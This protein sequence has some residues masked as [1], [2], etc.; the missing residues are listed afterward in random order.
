MLDHC[1]VQL[2][3]GLKK[4]KKNNQS[5]NM[6]KLSDGTYT[7]DHTDPFLSDA[8]VATSNNLASATQPEKER[9]RN[10]NTPKV[11]FPKDELQK[12]EEKTSKSKQ[13][14]LQA[15]EVIS[16]KQHQEST[17]ELGQQTN[18]KSDLHSS[19][20][21]SK[22]L[23]QGKTN[24]EFSKLNAKLT[25]DWC[26]P[27]E[28][29]AIFKSAQV[30]CLAGEYASKQL[31]DDYKAKYDEGHLSVFLEGIDT[32]NTFLLGQIQAKYK[33]HSFLIEICQSADSKGWTHYLLL[34]ESGRTMYHFFAQEKHQNSNCLEVVIK[35][36]VTSGRKMNLPQAT[37]MPNL[38]ENI[39]LSALLPGFR[40][41]FREVVNY[42]LLIALSGILFAL[43]A[44]F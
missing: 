36:I 29:S 32:E 41:S 16:L 18:H 42:L 23:K 33:A 4:E 1:T 39:L 28:R 20:D 9:K 30:I 25:K 35:A 44:N 24:E 12:P 37:S 17:H 38:P 11:E 40:I 7:N 5:G 15:S 43:A 22:P 6:V 34:D 3:C 14:D 26:H 31:N 19:N 2:F 21:S 10:S 8:K 13:H 27:S